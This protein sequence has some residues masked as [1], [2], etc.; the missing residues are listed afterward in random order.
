[1]TKKLYI[2]KFGDLMD[3]I[4]IFQNAQEVTFITQWALKNP[5]HKCDTPIDVYHLSPLRFCVFLHYH[6]GDRLVR[7]Y[8][9]FDILVLPDA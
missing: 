5:F 2:Q 3:R 4:W 8:L 1:M 9:F 6:S 7:E